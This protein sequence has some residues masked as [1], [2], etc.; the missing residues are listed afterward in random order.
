MRKTEAQR[1][2]CNVT[3]K[4]TS[5]RKGL[6]VGELGTPS[7]DLRVRGGFPGESF[8]TEPMQC[9]G[10]PPGMVVV[11]ASIAA[12]QD[13]Y[14]ERSKGG[15]FKGLRIEV[16]DSC[17]GRISKN[18]KEIT[19]KPDCMAWNWGFLHLHRDVPPAGFKLIVMPIAALSC[20]PMWTRKNLEETR[21]NLL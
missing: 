15:T 4:S 13:I 10:K 2:S 11:K 14:G 6:D 5:K 8:W 17:H 3:E 1:S 21:T 16:W 12:N 20:V 19:R 9:D 18:E 7:P